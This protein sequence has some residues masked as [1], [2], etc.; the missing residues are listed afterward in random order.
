LFKKVH[1]FRVK[2]K[3][4]LFAAIG[5]YCRDHEIRS[6]II[7]G[8]VGSAEK[9]HISFLEELPAKYAT[10]ELT[11][12]LEIV[13]AQGSVALKDGET[14]V[15][16]HIQL[17]NRDA[18]WGGHLVDATVFSSAEVTI[19]ELDYQLRRQLDTYTGNNELL[20]NN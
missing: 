11:G 9:A 17:S 8:I 5:R 13:A 16:I 7:I 20:E 18:C 4:E 14:W 6:G 15:H 2:P 19:G 12:P 3:Q 10:I 1:M